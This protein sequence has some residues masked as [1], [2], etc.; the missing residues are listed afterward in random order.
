MENNNQTCKPKISV[1]MGVYNSSKTLPES[2]QSIQNQTFKNWE[3][4]I[5]DDASTDD[6]YAVACT[7]AEGDS[8]IKVIKNSQNKKLAYSLNQ[9]LKIA[10]GQYIARMDAD[11]IAKDN[12]FEKQAE[13]L[14]LHPEY[15]VVGSA[16]EVSNGEQIFEVRSMKAEPTTDDV[17]F[18]APF[19]HPSIM[20]R[21]EV[22]DDLEGY[23]VAKRTIRGQ[24]RDLWFRFFAKGYKGY[25][26]Q[27]TYLTYFERPNE[28]KK[29]DFL[30]MTRSI[31]TSF[32]GY[33]LLKVPVW[34]YI[35]LVRIIISYATPQWLKRYVRKVNKRN[36]RL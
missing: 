14:D 17:L 2:I 3:L 10:L 19:I 20:M 21:K 18:G 24:D 25:N 26:L 27:E 4:I 32:Y 11:D 7:M 8:R 12:R 15:A 13:F 1:I 9:C 30:T 36:N 31:R 29:R 23:T 16:A 34:K 5:C 33:R 35:F 28:H 6:T 22:Y